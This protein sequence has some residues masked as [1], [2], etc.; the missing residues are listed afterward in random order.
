MT[1]DPASDTAAVIGGRVVV[2]VLNWNGGDDT[3]ECLA[4]LRHLRY[5]NVHTIVV[6]NGSSDESVANIGTAF[7][8]IPLIQTGVN[9]G[10]AG[11]NNVGI[12]AALATG[13]EY[14]LLLNNDTVVDPD[15]VDAFVE[16]ARAHPE[17]AL[18]GAKIYYHQEPDCIWYAGA[19]WAP[20]ISQFFHVG[21]G[22]R[23]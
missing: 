21:N 2:V 4:S 11:G 13:A 1:P 5:T 10:Y 22:E 16:A 14:V 18:F 23:D 7:P 19:R 15:C 9:L 6:D 8:E 20:E 12:R 3:L 17:G